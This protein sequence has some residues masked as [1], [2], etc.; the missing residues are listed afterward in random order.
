MKQ[1]YRS[2]HSEQKNNPKSPHPEGF[3]C[4]CQNHTCRGEHRS[5]VEATNLLYITLY[6]YH[7]NHVGDG[8]LD[9]PLIKLLVL[10]KSD[11]PPFWHFTISG[12]F[13]KF[14]VIRTNMCRGEHCSPVSLT[15][16]PLPCLLPH[17]THFSTLIKYL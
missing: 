10:Q 1:A 13:T 5:P 9:V 14:S 7:T 4:R 11:I 15:A 3:F 6:K 8:A 12:F 16:N 2:H 17:N